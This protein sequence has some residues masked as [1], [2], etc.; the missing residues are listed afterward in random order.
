MATLKRTTT[1]QPQYNLRLKCNK[2]TVCHI[3]DAFTKKIYKG[4]FHMSERRMS[5]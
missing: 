5:V 4:A 2:I 3:A 1:S